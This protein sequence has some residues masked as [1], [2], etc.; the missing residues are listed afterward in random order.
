MRRFG[1]GAL[2]KR[3]S[4]WPGF[5]EAS[6]DSVRPEPVSPVR[7]EPPVRHEAC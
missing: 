6:W 7:L 2:R 4:T 1:A 3:T 5:T